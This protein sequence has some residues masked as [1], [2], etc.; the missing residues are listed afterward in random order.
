M[1]SARPKTLS[2]AATR[3]TPSSQRPPPTTA[4]SSLNRARRGVDGHIAPKHPSST[5]RRCAARPLV[6]HTP[7][8]GG[9][10]GPGLVAYVLVSKFSAHLPLSRLADILIPHGVHLS[11]STLCDWVR[12]A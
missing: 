5:C 2:G 11:R 9:I 3:C 4:H 12:N 7:T 6:P 1:L 10:A 8:P